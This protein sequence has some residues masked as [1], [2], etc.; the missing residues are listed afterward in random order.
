LL[1]L[2]G[3]A[4]LARLLT[5]GAYPLFDNTE[6]RY[7]EIARKMAQTGNWITP[8]FDY[9]VPFWGKPPLSTWATAGLFDMFGVNEFTARLSSLLFCLGVVW[10]TYYLA[11]RRNGRGHGMAAVLVLSTTALFFVSSGGVMTDPALVLGTTLSM[12]A[13]WR[14]DESRLWGYLFFAGMAVGLLAKGP[15]AVVLTMLPVA[16]WVLVRKNPRETWRRLPWV[17]GTVLMFALALPWYLAA[18]HATPGF[19]DY[20]IIGEH[21]K[22]FTVSGWHGDLYGTAHSM[23]RGIIWPLWLLAAFP[24][25]LYLLRPASFRMENVKGLLGDGW[26]SYL[27]MWVLAPMVFFSFAG[28]VLWTYVLPGLPAFALLCN[29]VTRKSG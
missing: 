7:A 6:A 19:L 14:A 29:L 1:A 3:F 12:V 4:V 10:L 16:M 27:L 18:E 25:S 21:W 9:G 22:R 8:Q 15:V 23:P 11:D 5:L 28:N 13:F 17:T 26:R 2:L 20:F 24:W